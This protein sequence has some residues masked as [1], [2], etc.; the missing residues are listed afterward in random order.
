M[1]QRIAS[2]SVGP[3]C[4]LQ[5]VQGGGQTRGTFLIC[6][7]KHFVTTDVRVMVI[8][9]AGGRFLQ[10]RNKKEPFEAGGDHTHCC[11]ER[12]N[13]SVNRSC[14]LTHQGFEETYPVM[15]SGPAAFLVFPLL[16]SLLMSHS[17][18]SI[19]ALHT[20]REAAY[21]APPCFLR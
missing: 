5:Q 13:I 1:G 11:R 8:G 2:G 6:L 9:T 21:N 10:D 14:Q 12:L 3:V 4:K 16:N 20:L 18:V 15:Q 7:A 17:S 19:A